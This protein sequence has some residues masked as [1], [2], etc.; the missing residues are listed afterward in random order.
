MIK[1]GICDDNLK[2]TSHLKNLL[3]KYSE[4]HNLEF[5]INTFNNGYLFLDFIKNQ[6]TFDIC[7]LDIY[8][9]ALSG[10]DT[11]KELRL[12]DKNTQLIFTTS[13]KSFALDGYAVQ[14]T[15]YLIKPLK[16][17]DFFKAL[18]LIFEKT[19]ID[20]VENIRIPTITGVQFVSS[21][22]IS[23]IE[24][25]N[26]RCT[27]NLCNKTS[28]TSSINLTKIHE[29]FN[30]SISF[31]VVSRSILINLDSVVGLENEKLVLKDGTKITIPRRKKKELTQAFLDYS[32]LN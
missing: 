28:L 20:T 24:A 30:E 4:N 16:K 1:I 3:S 7:F 21:N 10:I 6:Q 27:V 31:I 13:S 19:S 29:L 2:E 25:S 18:D 15:N 12:L 17:D 22:M 26:N 9:P 23:Y 32:M 14:A 11:A 5:D 8:M